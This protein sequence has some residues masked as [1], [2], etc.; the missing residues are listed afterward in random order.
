MGG[1]EKLI[2]AMFVK[3]LKNSVNMLMIKGFSLCLIERF[4]F[5][6]ALVT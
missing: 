2:I 1:F 3:K 6:F 4:V 5:F